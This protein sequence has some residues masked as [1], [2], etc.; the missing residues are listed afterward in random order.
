MTWIQLIIKESPYLLWVSI[1]FFL[2]LALS[3]VT[4]IDMIK[5]LKREKKEISKYFFDFVGI[6]ILLLFFWP[7]ILTC[8]YVEDKKEKQKINK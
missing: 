2:G 7:L 5:D 4:I 8:L 6:L 3:F 1:Y